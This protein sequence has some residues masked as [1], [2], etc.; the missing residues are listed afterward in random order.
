MVGI[1]LDERMLLELKTS[2]IEPLRPITAYEHDEMK[3]SL[4]QN[5]V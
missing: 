5:S 4:R 1:N 2:Y 3:R